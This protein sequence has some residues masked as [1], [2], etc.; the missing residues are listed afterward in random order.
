MLPLPV[1]LPLF[2]LRVLGTLCCSACTRKNISSSNKIQRNY[3]ELKITTRRHSWSKLRTRYKRPNAQCPLLNNREPEQERCLPPAHG[4]PE[5]GT[6]RRLLD[7][8]PQSRVP[9]ADRWRGD[10]PLHMTSQ[11]RVPPADR[12]TRHPRPGVPPADRWTHPQPQPVPAAPSFSSY[13]LSSPPTPTSP[14]AAGAPVK[15]RLDF[16][17]DL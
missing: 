17:S 9:P 12:W 5:P 6:S 3:K 16:L 11:S 10:C 15:P 14:V 8:T 2:P 7:M 1:S 13:C 4:T